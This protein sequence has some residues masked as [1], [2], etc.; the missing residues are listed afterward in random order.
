MEKKMKVFAVF[1]VDY[2][3]EGYGLIDY[4]DSL[5]ATKESAEKAVEAAKNKDE[6]VDYL[7]KEVVINP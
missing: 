2:D 7:I 1:F 6:A 4:F 3:G 5:Y